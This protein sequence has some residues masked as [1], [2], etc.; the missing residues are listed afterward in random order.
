MK[1][2]DFY[3]PVTVV[4]NANGMRECSEPDSASL[5]RGIYGDETT[6]SVRQSDGTT[7]ECDGIIAPDGSV[8]VHTRSYRDETY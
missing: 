1:R 2:S 8:W 5:Q 7:V 4:G 6:V 3:R